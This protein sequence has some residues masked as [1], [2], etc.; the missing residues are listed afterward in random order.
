MVTAAKPGTPIHTVVEGAF[1]WQRTYSQRV[2]APD[3]SRMK[4][5]LLNGSPHFLHNSVES[6]P[7][8]AICT[9]LPCK[10]GECLRRSTK[11]IEGRSE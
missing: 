2:R 5:L 9:I 10:T 8:T 1:G 11:Y 7:L 3:M 6:H 4:D